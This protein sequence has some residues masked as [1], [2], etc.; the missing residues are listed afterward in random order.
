MS[1][2]SLRRIESLGIENSLNSEEFGKECRHC[3]KRGA[4][5]ASILRETSC[6]NEKDILDSIMNMKY[7][8]QVLTK[9]S[10]CIRNIQKLIID[11]SNSQKFSY[12]NPPKPKDVWRWVRFICEEYMKLK[13]KY[14]RD[15]SLASIEDD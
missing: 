8:L 4:L 11:C 14:I 12:K 15:T 1:T 10:K 6:E 2:D 5:I 3:V 9:N 7:D 13:K